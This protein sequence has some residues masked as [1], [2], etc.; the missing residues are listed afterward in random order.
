MKVLSVVVLP[1]FVDNRIEATLGPADGAKLC[2]LIL[3]LVLIVRMTKYFLYFFKTNPALRIL[4]QSPAL[5][6]VK[7][8][9]HHWTL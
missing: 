2:R 7:R 9:A 1:H 8:E 4:L 5:L 3:T 6:F